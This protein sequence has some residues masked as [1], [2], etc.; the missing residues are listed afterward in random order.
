MKSLKLTISKSTQIVDEIQDELIK[1]DI[2]F[3]IVN[4]NQERATPPI[5][6]IIVTLG[7]AGVFTAL[8][9]VL[10]KLIEKYKDAE[11]KIERD[12]TKATIKGYNPKQAKAMLDSIFLEK[13]DILHEKSQSHSKKKRKDA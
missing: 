13:R 4:L 2:D 12:K 3:T 1:S 6:D 8:Y 9:R 11:I 10:L 5:M 7:S